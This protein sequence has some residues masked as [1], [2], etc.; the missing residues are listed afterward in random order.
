MALIFVSSV[1]MIPFPVMPDRA[2]NLFGFNAPAWS[3]FW[4]YIANIIYA[5]AL[6]KIGRRWLLILTLLSA[7]AICLV[8]YRTGNIMG[9]WGGPNFWDGFVRVCYSFLAGL[10]IYRY[11]W[12]IKN[13]LGFPGLAVLLALALLMP[14]TKWNWLTEPLVVL[15]Y[16]PLLIVLG[17]GATL[18]PQL[19]KLC[20]FSGN[21]SYP[22]YMTHYAVIWAFANYY[23]SHKPG[24]GLLAVII[25]T[26]LVLLIG[27]AWVALVV[28]DIPVHNYLTSKRKKALK[29]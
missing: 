5:L 22:L 15:F 10:L 27:I 20:N 25:L 12:I 14:F 9:G 8:T 26:S 6:Y 1:L 28:Y 3:L 19:K 23:A 4:E 13:K 21:I 17:A 29:Q 18:S 2:L 7:V 16:F 24:T 11:K